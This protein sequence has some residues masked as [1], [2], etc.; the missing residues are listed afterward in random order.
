[1][2]EKHALGLMSEVRKDRLAN[3][4]SFR[5]FQ[6]TAIEFLDRHELVNGEVRYDDSG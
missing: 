4:E 6:P 3:G 1:M 5:P 2:L